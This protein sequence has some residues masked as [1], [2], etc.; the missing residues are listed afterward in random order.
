MAGTEITKSAADLFG[1]PLEPRNARDKLLVTAI[2]LFYRH[3]FNAVGL[4]RIIDET[5]VTKT[6]FY[7]YFESKDDLMVAALKQRDQWEREAWVRAV[8]KIAGDDPRA[9][10]LAIFGV[11]DIWFNDPSFGG[12]LFINAAAE[13][14]DKNDPVHQAAAEH[15]KHSRDQFRDLAKAAGAKDPE[16]FADLFA[17]LIEG[18]LIMR[19]VHHRNDAA[20]LARAVAEQLVEEYISPPARG[21]D[22]AGRA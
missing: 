13:F 7:K 20:K 21:S 17:L 5:G 6:S 4:D 11:L 16:P 12:C 1:V 14:P 3:G 8:R 2:D 19:H 9:Q 15:K 10:L 18:T 22:V